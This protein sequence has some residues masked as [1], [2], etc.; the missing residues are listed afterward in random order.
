[1]SVNEQ[2]FNEWHDHYQNRLL[3][4]MAGIV[5]D[6]GCAEDVT[7]GAIAEAWTKR[8]QFRGESSLYTWI[9][10][11]ARNRALD[12]AR[13]RRTLSLDAPEL[14]AAEPA[15]SDHFTRDLERAQERHRLRQALR[16]LPSRYRQVLVEHFIHGSAVK[17]I[18]R[19]SE[20]PLGTALS[21]IATAKRLLRA[22]WEA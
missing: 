10:R 4:S 19:R 16:Q 9:Y 15:E 14:G 1:M 11:I 12:V 5:K 22:A 7:A 3:K 8:D 20:I 21:R 6:E 18:A 17:E 2:Q 13:Q